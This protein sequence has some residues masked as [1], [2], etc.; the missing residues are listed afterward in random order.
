LK[1][2]TITFR[3]QNVKQKCTLWP[4]HLQESECP[5]R[6]NFTPVNDTA[7]PQNSGI[8][9]PSDTASISQNSILGYNAR[10]TFKTCKACTWHQK[11]NQNLLILKRYS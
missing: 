4:H 2:Q 11:M 7:M 1:Q 10:K 9:L 8:W 5:R 3:G 6:A